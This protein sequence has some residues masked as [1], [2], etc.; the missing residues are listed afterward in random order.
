MKKFTFIF[1]FILLSNLSL[2]AIGS[3]TLFRKEEPKILI[4]NRIL[5]FVNGKPIS[6]YDL[7]RKMDLSFFKQFPQYAS[8]N[9]ARFQFYTEGW[10]SFLSEMIDKELILADAKESKIEISSGDI[11]QE[12][13]SSFGP[14]VIEN[15]DKAGLTYEEA[16]KIME[17]DMIIQR[18]LGGRAHAKALRVVTPV[19]VREKYE[20]YI[21]DP[22]NARHTQ[23]LYRI[24]TIQERTSERAATAANTAYQ[25]LQENV[26]LDDVI[27]KLKE[28]KLIGRKGKITVSKTIKQNDKEIS[29]A[30][31]EIL[32]NLEEK[33]YSSPFLQK[34]RRNKINVYRILLLEEKIPGGVPSFKEVSKMLKDK[35]LNDEINRETDNYLV[36]LRRHYHIRDK[37]VENSLP[38]GYQ[39]FVLN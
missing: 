24:L 7:M 32:S 19:K 35:L 9:E 18:L 15:L 30:F 26:A 1:A 11:R 38:Q 3:D 21:K 29:D 6:T 14:N 12:I 31:A 33:N 25:L 20:E 8:S 22:A 17:E 37:D 23:W 4:N 2:H 27:A 36:K 39:P 10:K 28:D 16:A 13:E 34:S 5:T